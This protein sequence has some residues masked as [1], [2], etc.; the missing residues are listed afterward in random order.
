MSTLSPQLHLVEDFDDVARLMEWIKQPRPF[1]GV[2]TETGGLDW[3]RDP[4]RMVQVGDANTGWA[5]PF[6]RWKGVCHQILTEYTRP[7]ALH[8]SKF[9][10]HFLRHNGISLPQHL[11]HDTMLMVSV[12]EPTKSSALKSASGRLIDPMAELGQQELKIAFM[13]NKWNWA[14]VPL[15]LPAY[16]IY[17]ALDPVLTAMLAELLLPQVAQINQKLYDIELGSMFALGEMEARGIRVDREYSREHSLILGEYEAEM[18]KWFYNSYGIENPGSDADMIKFFQS[19]GIHFTKKTN[20]GKVALDKTV[21]K[22]LDHPAAVPLVDFRE[23][24]K[25]RST[26]FDNFI[27]FADDDG[28]I[29]TQINPLGARTGRMSAERPNL[30]NVPRSKL[31]RSAFIPRDNNKLVLV[32][33]DQIELRLMA[34]YAQEDEMVKAVLEGEDLH[35]FVGRMIYGVPE[36]TKAQRQVTKNANFAKIY[37]AGIAKFADTAGIEPNEAQQFMGMYDQR[38]SKIGKFA[39]SLINTVRSE[40]EVISP[41]LG[42]IQSVYNKKDAYKIVN[43]FIQGTAADVL[44]TKIV[45]L[46]MTDISDFM[47][48]PI[49]DEIAFDVP[50]ADVEEVQHLAELVMV[51]RTSFSLPLSVEGEVV[52]KW[53]DK[54]E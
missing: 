38:F 40:G 18:R 37:G 30:Q 50:E 36:L 44:K 31:V 46:S 12:V 13:K 23:A 32:D 24:V 7:M 29:H 34:H 51:D 16:W 3:W 42:R 6:D 21:L 1:L 45:E 8:N 20:K 4:L 2:D 5:I 33:F 53:G 9:D 11:I 48:I 41:Y 27:E 15:D 52:D 43:Y 26:Y 22:A 39:Q 35:T 54:Y 25:T 14:T 49:H 17:A 19:E 47:L 28:F 10:V